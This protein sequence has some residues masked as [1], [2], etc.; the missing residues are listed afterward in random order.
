MLVEAE[1]LRLRD[2]NVPKAQ[3]MIRG[4][5]ATVLPFYDDLVYEHTSRIVVSKWLRE[6][7]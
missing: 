4:T 6:N 2:R 1:E 3:L 5:N 7:D